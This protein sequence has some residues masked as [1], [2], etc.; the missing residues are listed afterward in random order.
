[1]VCQRH[2]KA[3]GAPVSPTRVIASAEELEAAVG[4]EIGVSGWHE[5]GQPELDA[6]ADATGDR[7]WIHVDPERAA[8]SEYGTTI[9]HGLYIL[10]LGPMFMYAIVNFDRLGT[11]LNYGYDTVRFVAP[12]PCGSRVR[13]RVRLLSLDRREIGLR[14]TFKQTFEV[15]RSESPCCV[16]TFV[17]YFRR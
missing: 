13:M 16:A 17:E 6:F 10:S 14:A 1:M 7:Y 8:K 15:E 5:V 4:F 11:A 2:R 9:A 3:A 12:L